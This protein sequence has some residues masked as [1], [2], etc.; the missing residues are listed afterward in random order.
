MRV[1]CFCS[2]QSELDKKECFQTTCFSSF[3]WGHSQVHEF[4]L[5]HTYH[6]C[7]WETP[8]WL[9]FWRVSWADISDWGLWFSA[10]SRPLLPFIL[11]KTTGW[12]EKWEEKVH[13]GL[14]GVVPISTLHICM[15]SCFSCVQLFMTSWTVAYLV[16]CLWD[17]P[18]KNSEVGCHALLQ[19]IFP[20]PGSNPRLLCLLH[21]QAGSLP[22][23]PPGKPI[24]HLIKAK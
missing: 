21:Q 2:H 10:S 3:L 6:H 20:T 9:S 19:G 13:T 14:E 8:G 1:G 5:P 24:L 16:L 15:L 11:R 12:W 4:M 7:L 18:G 17:S 23:A 22:L